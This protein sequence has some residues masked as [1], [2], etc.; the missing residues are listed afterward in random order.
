MPPTKRKFL[1][2]AAFAKRQDA[3]FR[4]RLP[5]KIGPGKNGRASR[6]PRALVV[7]HLYGPVTPA[8]YAVWC[9][10]IGRGINQPVSDQIY[11]DGYGVVISWSAPRLVRRVLLRPRPLRHDRPHWTILMIFSEYRQ[12]QRRLTRTSETSGRPTEYQR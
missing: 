10:A 2:A 11:Y 3:K 1:S 12:D 5:R 6:I 9:W 8:M 7:G 4:A